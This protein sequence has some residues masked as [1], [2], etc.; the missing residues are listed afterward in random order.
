MS[1]YDKIYCY[2]DAM[3]D[4]IPF[5][6]S[7]DRVPIRST[8]NRMLKKDV[9]S[10]VINPARNKNCFSTI[11]A[12][13]EP[14]RDKNQSGELHYCGIFFDLDAETDEG[15][16]VT[17]EAF[18]RAVSDANCIINFF[19]EL[20]IDEPC[21]KVWFSGGRGFHILINPDPFNITPHRHLTYIIKTIALYLKSKYKLNTLD[22]KIYTA[23]R[24]WRIPNTEHHTTGL[25]KTELYHNELVDDYNAI[26]ELCSKARKEPLYEKEEY[27]NIVTQDEP[28][29]FWKRFSEQ[30]EFQEKVKSLRPT[31]KI[32][33]TEKWPSCVND[34]LKGGTKQP[35]TRNKATVILACYLKDTGKTQNE[36][37]DILLKW[38][39]SLK[40]ESEKKRK[41]RI[42]N[43]YA[44]V[45]QVYKD[46]KYHFSCKA[47]R[48]LGTRDHGVD[49]SMQKGNKCDT[50]ESN[51]DNQ[52]P[53]RKIRVPLSQ[54]S[55]SAFVGCQ[56]EIPVLITGKGDSPF[57]YP[58]KGS[59]RCTPNLAT[60]VCQECEIV[61]RA[62]A[63][64]GITPFEFPDINKTLIE[65]INCNS[66]RK[67]AVIKGCYGV[68]SKCKKVKVCVSEYRN[69]HEVRLQ[70]NIQ[71]GIVGLR[72]LEG[73][74]AND[75]VAEGEFCVRRAY[76][77]GKDIKINKKYNIN[78]HVLGHP[79]DQKICH[80]FDEADAAQD[81]VDKFVLTEDM[82]NLL[83]AFR[84]VSGQTVEDKFCDIHEDLESNVHMIWGRRD[85]AIAVD[86]VY[87]SVIGFNFQQRFVKKGWMELLIL[88]DSGNGKTKMVEEIMNHYQLGEITGVEGGKRTGLIWANHHTGSG[89]ILVWG[90]IP[91]NDRRLIVLDE[92]SGMPDEE[93]A[94]MTRLRTEGVAESQG[95]NPAQTNAR[96]RM[97]F[98]SN[99]RNGKPLN[100]YNHGIEAINAL[101]RE[102]QDVRRLDM[103][104]C[105]KTGDVPL[106]LI[107]KEHIPDPST[108]A[109]TSGLCKDLVL[110]A[111][112]RNPSQIHILKESEQLILKHAT[113]L[114]KRYLCDIVLVEPSDQRLK[115]ARMACA[116]AARMFSSDEE[117]GERLI[118]RPEHVEFAVELTKRLYGAPAMEY[119]TYAKVAQSKM[120]MSDEV[121]SKLEAQWVE[122][123]DYEHLIELFL[124]SNY[125]RKRDL[126]DL[127]GYTN[128]EIG[129]LIKMLAKYSL[130][131]ST[132]NYGYRKTP[133]FTTWLKEMRNA[134]NAKPPF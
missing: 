127:T 94:A 28:M 111:W 67:N 125:F 19:T 110:W 52:K 35:G 23:R 33:Y 75:L 1:K 38:V 14:Q 29:E 51:E 104:A 10:R 24:M 112:S 58:F 124:S 70:P 89:Y 92:F 90:K 88:G 12:F 76:F 13:K 102:H 114:G 45:R 62:D 103:A 74:E 128:D 36:A 60:S 126:Q 55:D 49:C 4:K 130:L 40:C 87:H 115:L 106:E 18:S 16:K 116:V 81:N 2:V 39:K 105:V 17:K 99:P 20:G 44:V 98:L 34:I 117:T 69:I 77:I 71:S 57:V 120:V 46:T 121:K 26:C 82:R 134:F 61:E 22:D 96:V 133:M 95:I 97:I 43:T 123:D 118:V 131:V 93:V 30:F 15:G 37:L 41:E 109:Y 32:V 3:W 48:S 21:I 8:W 132:T 11:Q 72:M 66:A 9:P 68:N 107:N 101:F 113:E 64:E 108:H 91:Q 100:Y 31:K 27:E 129:H 84:P 79:S 65:V 6:Q 63:N 86:L 5:H 47:I 119:E 85:I 59:F 42:S 122:L 53:Q 25:Y 73:A 80:M 78:A 56:V 54:A 50:I 7:S 83:K